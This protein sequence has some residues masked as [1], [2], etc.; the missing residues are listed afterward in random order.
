[1]PARRL[2]ELAMPPSD[3]M[4][5]ARFVRQEHELLRAV[6][7]LRERLEVAL[8]DQILRRIA[9][10]ADRLRDHLNRLRLGLRDAQPRLRL[11]FG[12]ENRRL[13]RR[14]RR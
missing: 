14:L 9:G 2:H 1:M 12:R 6:R 10:R 13:L 5:A 8:R 7:D 4:H 3:A 11:T